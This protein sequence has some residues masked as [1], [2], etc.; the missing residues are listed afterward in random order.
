MNIIRVNQ[1]NQVNIPKE[2]ADHVN[3]GPDRYVQVVAEGNVIRLIPVTAEPLYS[4]EAL[5]CL[6]RLVKREKNKAKE[7]SGEEQ[8]QKLFRPS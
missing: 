4:K 8:I 7:I 2:I 3:F 6:D 1:R 5:E